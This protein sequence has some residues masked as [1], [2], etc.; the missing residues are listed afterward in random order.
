KPL[1]ENYAGINPRALIMGG[2]IAG[3]V[4]ALNLA[5]QGHPVTL[6]EKEHDLGGHLKKIVFTLS[7]DDPQKLLFNL[8]EKI[9]SNTNIEVLVNSEVTDVKGYVGNF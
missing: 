4:V 6:I 9:I 1:L 2:G 5:E 7:G 3:V 8:R